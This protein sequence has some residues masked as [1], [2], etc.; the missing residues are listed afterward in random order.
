[1]EP[2]LL[3]VDEAAAQLGVCRTKVYAWWQAAPWRPSRSIVAGGFAARIFSPSSPDSPTP[4]RPDEGTTA[5]QA[6][7]DRSSTQRRTSASCSTP[8]A[9]VLGSGCP[10]NCTGGT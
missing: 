9:D 6:T 4:P 8:L 1:M 2:L 10:R 3:T 5:A 7:K